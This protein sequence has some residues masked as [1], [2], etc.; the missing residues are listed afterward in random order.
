MNA[1]KV[2]SIL[3]LVCLVIV[4]SI[5]AV[6]LFAIKKVETDAN[7]QKT[8]AARRARWS[9]EPQKANEG[10]LSEKKSLAEQSENGENL[11]QENLMRVADGQE[12]EE[13]L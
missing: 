7:R 10:A 12:Q 5:I 4:L 8:E 9:R 11:E 2:I 1:R 3:G 6:A 13:N